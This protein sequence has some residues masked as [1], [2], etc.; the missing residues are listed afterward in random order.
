MT[1]GAIK[2]IDP[3]VEEKFIQVFFNSANE[4]EAIRKTA[5]NSNIDLNDR[6]REWLT[7]LH[8]WI[9]DNNPIY[10]AYQQTN[11]YVG[12]DNNVNLIFTKHVPVTAEGDPRTYSDPNENSGVIRLDNELGMIID[13][14]HAECGVKYDHTILSSKREGRICP[15]FVRIIV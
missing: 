14:T 7:T 10:A 3:S 15:V 4:E 6:N 9:R 12:D 11:D 1:I 5:S 2:T 13:S 8:R